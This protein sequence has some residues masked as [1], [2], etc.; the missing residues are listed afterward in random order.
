MLKN[1][2][3]A[4]KQYFSSVNSALYFL[5]GI[6]T[7]VGPS[8]GALIQGERRSSVALPEGFLHAIIMTG[9]LLAASAACV[10]WVR[11]E[12]SCRDGWKW[13]A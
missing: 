11:V 10:A 3:R 8:T 12:K 13:K 9:V 6:G 2:Y 4:F 5:Q 7:L 1:L